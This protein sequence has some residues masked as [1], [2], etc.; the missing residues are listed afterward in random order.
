MCINCILVI[1]LFCC[2]CIRGRFMLYNQTICNL[3][4][5]MCS[6]N[7]LDKNLSCILNNMKINRRCSQD[8]F[9]MK[10]IYITHFEKNIQISNLSTLQFI[11]YSSNKGWILRY[12]S[13]C[14]LNNNPECIFHKV[15]KHSQNH[16]KE[17]FL[18]KVK[19]TAQN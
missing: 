7:C 4:Q 12:K 16:K 9:L 6:N 5:L 17:Y 13:D 15:Q 19:D 2:F 14:F 11:D 18:F 3:C 8:L 1:W 10:D